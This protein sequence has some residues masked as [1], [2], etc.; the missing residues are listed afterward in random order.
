VD[1]SVVEGEVSAP[2][3]CM[4]KRPVEGESAWVGVC[5]SHTRQQNAAPATKM[6]AAPKNP[7]QEPFAFIR[8]GNRFSLAKTERCLINC[9][10]FP[11]RAMS[12]SFVATSARAARAH[13]TRGC[14]FL[15]RSCYVTLLRRYIRTGRSGLGMGGETI[16]VRL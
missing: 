16:K 2:T 1:I 6:A 3:V 11:A 12:R 10:I 9:Y 5:E 15:S 13:G 7:A 8:I 4:S 14:R